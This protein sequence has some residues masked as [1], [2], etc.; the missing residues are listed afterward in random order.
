[1][2]FQGLTLAVDHG[3]VQ[4]DTAR[5]MD[6]IVGCVTI[7][8]VN[9]ER[10]AYDVTDAHG[11]VTISVSKNDVKVH[12]HNAIPQKSK[13]V[14][15]DAVLHP[16]EHASRPDLCGTRFEKEPGIGGMLDTLPAQI[17]GG[18]MVA[19]IICFGV[20]HGDDPVSPS[21]P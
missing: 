17:L 19:A 1:M 15:G 9:S 4:V 18:A 16:G 12:T 14:P 21:K 8:P 20:C 5:E 6:V 10:T 11:T 3:T 7:S 13:G 2:Q